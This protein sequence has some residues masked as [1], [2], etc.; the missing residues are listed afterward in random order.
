MVQMNKMLI[1]LN[2]KE[3]VS[4]GKWVPLYLPGHGIIWVY[5]RQAIFAPFINLYFQSNGFFFFF[6][7]SAA[8]LLTYYYGV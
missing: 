5:S 1:F 7:S 2:M 4:Q 8:L 6:Y 3:T